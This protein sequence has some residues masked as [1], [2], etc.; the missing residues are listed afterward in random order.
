MELVFIS[1]VSGFEEVEVVVVVAAAVVEEDDDEVITI[2]ESS[3]RSCKS[4]TGSSRVP[5]L[6]FEGETR[7]NIGFFENLRNCS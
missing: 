3:S 1:I 2:D 4:L 7:S 6:I 5:S